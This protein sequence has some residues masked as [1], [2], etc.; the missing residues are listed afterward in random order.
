MIDNIVDENIRTEA[1]ETLD[2]L[3]GASH[4][5]LEELAI[6]LVENG[7]GVQGQKRERRLPLPLAST[8]AQS[9]W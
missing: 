7:Y 1:Q 3:E 9:A 8:Y 6:Q 2:W 5:E 4:D